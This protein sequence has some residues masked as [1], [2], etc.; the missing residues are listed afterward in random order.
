MQHGFQTTYPGTGGHQGYSALGDSG[1][2]CEDTKYTHHPQSPFLSLPKGRRIGEFLNSTMNVSPSPN[3]PPKQK[4]WDHPIPIPQFPG[5]PKGG[6]TAPPGSL[7][8]LFH[9]GF[10][11]ELTALSK[12]PLSSPAF[13]QRLHASQWRRTRRLD[14]RSLHCF[15]FNCHFSKQ[16]PAAEA[17]SSHR[18]LAS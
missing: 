6:W 17:R 4:G 3:K 5:P 14:F 13:Q 12:V 7:G 11:P 2:K 1:K 8:G 18:H 15:Q 10:F 16:G 9:Q